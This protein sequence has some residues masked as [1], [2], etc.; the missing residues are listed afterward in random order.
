MLKLIKT[1]L[2]ALLCVIAMSKG[3]CQRL[4]DPALANIRDLKSG[5]LWIVLQTFDAKIEALRAELQS[6]PTQTRAQKMLDQSV[7]E[8]DSFNLAIQSSIVSLYR[9]S[10]FKFIHDSALTTVL[11]SLR[12]KDAQGHYFLDH[13]YT[14][15]GAGALVISDL[16]RKKLTKPFPYFVRT[17]KVSVLIDTIFGGKDQT[18]RYVRDAVKKLDD[19]LHKFYDKHY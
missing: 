16:N 9:F 4:V 10:T 17:V 19:R 15:N 6:D 13:S 11:D 12:S 18:W 3:Y 1:G 2:I 8:R 7:A 14:E 5:T